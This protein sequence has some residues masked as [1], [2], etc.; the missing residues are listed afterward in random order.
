MTCGYGQDQGMALSY[1]VLWQPFD[2][3]PPELP[4]SWKVL[5][6]LEWNIL[7]FSQHAFGHML[8]IQ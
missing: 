2:T 8:E 5:G 6:K 1:Y 4:T 3:S 7:Y